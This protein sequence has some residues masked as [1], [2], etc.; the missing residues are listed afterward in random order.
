MARIGD[1]K[2]DE[3]KGT[4]AMA[5]NDGEGKKNQEIRNRRFLPFLIIK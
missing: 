2:H 5:K 1:L 3:L 4:W